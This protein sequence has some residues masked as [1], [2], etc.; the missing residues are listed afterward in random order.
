[1]KIAFC[2]DANVPSRSAESIFIMKMCESFALNGHDVTLMV[3]DVPDPESRHDPYDFYGIEK[4]FPIRRLPFISLPG[5]R[6]LCGMLAAWHAKRQRT[7]LVYARSLYTAYFATL[8]GLPCVIESHTPIADTGKMSDRVFRTLIK[9]PALRRLVVIT[10]SLKQYYC[11]RY[12]M[13]EHM[14]QVAPDAADDMAT[15]EPLELESDRMSVGY[16]GHLYPGKGMEIIGELSGHCPW[17]DFHCVGGTEEDISRWKRELAERSNVIFHGFVRP[18]EVPRYCRTFDVLVAPYLRNISA[19]DGAGS[20]LAH[21]T[22]PLKLFEY[23]SAAKPIVC[24]DLPVLREVMTDDHNA[25]LCDPDRI[26]TWVRALERLRDD[27]ELGARLGRSARGEFEQKY[28]WEARTR[29][30]VSGL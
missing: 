15:A 23:M 30:V 16:V 13:P 21:W 12:N 11:E 25:L 17:A 6:A 5:K 29:A 1:M 14:V 19:Y 28:T 3:P 9:S 4:R 10:E 24:S 27:A 18:N 7:D 20:N 8:M 2:P 22:S 26:D